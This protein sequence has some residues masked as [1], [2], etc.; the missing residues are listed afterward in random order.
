MQF[1][2]RSST[3]GAVFSQ[4]NSDFCCHNHVSFIFLFLFCVRKFC[5]SVPGMVKNRPE[6]R[7]NIRQ[8]LNEISSDNIKEKMDSDQQH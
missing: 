4:S 5:S 1:A 2:A 8:H 6:Q 7:R 3:V